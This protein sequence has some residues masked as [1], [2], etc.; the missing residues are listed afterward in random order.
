MKVKRTL[1]PKIGEDFD[2][3]GSDHNAE[4]DDIFMSNLQTHGID[5]NDIIGVQEVNDIHFDNSNITTGYIIY[6]KFE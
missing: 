5:V 6:H 2:R 4:M 1:I 3:F